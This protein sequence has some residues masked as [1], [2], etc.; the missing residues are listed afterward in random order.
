MSTNTSSTSTIGWVALG[1]GYTIIFAVLLLILMFT[2]DLFFGPVNDVF[3]G[4]FGLT[5]AVLAW[6]FFPAHRAK[7][8]GISQ[9]ALALALVGAILGIVGSAL[10]LADFTGF[11]LAGL[12]SGLGNALIGLWLLIFSYS[13]QNSDL[14]PRRLLWFGFVVGAFMSLGLLGIP[15]IFAGIDDMASMPG[16]LYVALSGWLGTYLLYP[17]WTIGLGKYLLAK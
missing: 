13:M 3:N 7:L 10:I 14:L 15:G 16:Y 5:S 4:I 2:V 11:L 8:P 1:T 6:R 17:I 12:Y 9:V